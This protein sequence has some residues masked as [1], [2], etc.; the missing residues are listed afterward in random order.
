[1]KLLVDENLSFRLV[2]AVQHL[3]PGS[4]H[5]ASL[6]LAGASDDA[7]WD[8]AREHGFAIVS[9]DAHFRQRG[10]VEGPPPRIVWLDVGN[11]STD[12]IVALL[13]REHARVLA[14][15]GDPEAALLVL[16]LEA[17]AP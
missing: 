11:A 3:F 10:F 17:S 9:K 1:M 7:V 2:P 16:P 14:F 12:S 4:A 8:Y 15:D 13:I 5:V 6:G